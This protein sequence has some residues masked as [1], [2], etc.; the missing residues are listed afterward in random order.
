MFELEHPSHL[1]PNDVIVQEKIYRFLN[2]GPGGY[3]LSAYADNAATFT[4]GQTIYIGG[5]GGVAPTTT[6]D[7][8]RIYPPRPGNIRSVTLWGQFGTAGT[9]ESWSASLRLNNTTDY[10][11][12][13]EAISAT[14]RLWSN[15][16]MN[17][18]VVVGDYFEIKL[19]N[20]TWATNPANGRFGCAIY[21]G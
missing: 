16:Q 9:A 15:T 6:A 19:V 17:I 10:L 2:D 7:V 8:N 12:E 20:P 18:E 14:Y 5:R 21:I 11:I 13:A 4:D 1:N 3:V